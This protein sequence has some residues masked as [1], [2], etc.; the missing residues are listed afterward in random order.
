MKCLHRTRP[1]ERVRGQANLLC[2]KWI[3]KTQEIIPYCSCREFFKTVDAIIREFESI[4]LLD[5]T[6]PRVGIVGEILVKYHPGANDEIVKY[7]EKEGCEVVVAGLSEFF[8][9]CASNPIWH[10]KYLRGSK[11][12]AIQSQIVVFFLSCIQHRINKSLSSSNIFDPYPSIFELSRL[13]S[14]TVS[15]CNN[16]GEGW[17]L[18]AD[19]VSLIESGTSN[20]VCIQPFGCLPNHVLGRGTARDIRRRYPGS[21]I[22]SL[23]Y[24]PGI[25]EANRQNRLKLFLSVAR[26]A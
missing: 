26:S 4:P 20:I 5:Q 10:E 22:L 15:L 13:A 24:D 12:A 9:Y 7:L 14:P 25:S 8:L 16:A 6:K 1:Y 19:S 21:N 2:E 23:D 18:V 11:V 3:K 17:Y